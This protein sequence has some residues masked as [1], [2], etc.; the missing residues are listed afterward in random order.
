VASSHA[1]VPQTTVSTGVTT[2]T[3]AA[4]ASSNGTFSTTIIAPETGQVTGT[5]IAIDSTAAFVTFGSA[6]TVAAWNPGA[7]SGRCI[8]ITTS[9]SGDGGTFSIAGR[10]MYGYKMTETLAVSQG[11]TNSSGATIT[12]QKAFKYISAITNTS[13]PTS[14]SVSIGISNRFGF[15]LNV[16]YTGQNALINFNSSA[17]IATL[18]PPST[19]NTIVASTVATQTSTT[20]DVRGTFLSTTAFNSIARLQMTIT[21]TA[22]GVATITSTNVRPLFGGAQF[23]S[24]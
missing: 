17:T 12:S 14:T 20:P 16:P 3:L 7:G 22:S 21:P 4:A 23:S 10:D 19:T 6:G 9:S 24:V 5:L 11:T 1:F 15:P 2:F 8:V 18:V 13:T